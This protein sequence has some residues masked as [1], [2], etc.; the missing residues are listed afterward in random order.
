MKEG[1]ARTGEG[2]SMTN[3][4]RWSMGA[5]C[6]AVLALAGC[7]KKTEV[8]ALPPPEVSVSQPVE[9]PVA[10]YFETTGQA[11]AVESVDIRAR[12]SGYLTRVGFVDGTEVKKGD[13]LFVID[14]RPYEAEV[15]R[16]EAEV[17]RWEAS[18]RKS[19]A[20]VERNRRLLPKGAASEKDLEASIAARDSAAAEIQA[21]RAKLQ[22]AKLDLEFTRVTAPISGQV[23][24]TNVTVGN[25][26][27]A[28]GT[29]PNLLTT[30]VSVDPIYV[31]FDIDERTLLRQRER[32]RASGRPIGSD[33][34]RA[35]KI[36]IEVGLAGDEGYPHHGIFDFVDNRVDPGTG[37]IK[38]RGIFTNGDRVLAPGLFVRVR[39]PIGDERPVLLVTERAI[40]TDQGNKFVYVVNDQN[41]VEYRSVKLGAKADDG[42]RA[43]TEGIRAGEWVMVNGI[44][45]ARPGLTVKPQQ[46]SMLPPK[47]EAAAP[48]KPAEAAKPHA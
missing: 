21:A 16:S 8:V 6:A 13:E 7:E 27:T 34:V 23:S 31:Y 48:L 22:Q 38:A 20:D 35:E 12:V 36:P 44:Q 29:D 45:R 10:E 30:L 2:S 40:G 15:M 43:I 3:C 9:R 19:V 1:D 26:V 47:P 46:V 25:L 37:T 41:A 14:P 33:A 11:G 5:A 18:H 39:V 42:L 24:R 32:R 17:A 4:F 28:T